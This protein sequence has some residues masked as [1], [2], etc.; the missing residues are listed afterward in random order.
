MLWE[1]VFWYMC[2]VFRSWWVD[3]DTTSVG[4]AVPSPVDNYVLFEYAFKV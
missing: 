3:V 1:W 4:V 2:S